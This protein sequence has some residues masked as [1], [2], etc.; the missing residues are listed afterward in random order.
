[1]NGKGKNIKRQGGIKGKA[2]GVLEKRLVPL[3]QLVKSQVFKAT[4]VEMVVEKGAFLKKIVKTNTL[5]TLAI[6]TVE[7]LIYDYKAI[8]SNKA[9]FTGEKLVVENSRVVGNSANKILMTTAGSLVGTYVG[10]AIGSLGGPFGFVVG[11]FVGGII[12]A[13]VG[14]WA[15]KYTA[16]FF[17]NKSINIG[18]KMSC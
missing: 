7:E 2:G 1:M 12:G 10:A 5:G 8:N 4:G 13:S 9:Y 6:S 17:V 14:G 15:A 16:N 3:P 11:S 18:R